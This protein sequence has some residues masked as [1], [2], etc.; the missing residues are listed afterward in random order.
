MASSQ[1]TLIS[2]ELN[3]IFNSKEHTY[4][5]SAFSKTTKKKKKHCF[6]SEKFSNICFQINLVTIWNLLIFILKV[7]FWF[8]IWFFAFKKVEDGLVWKANFNQNVGHYQKKKSIFFHF[9][10]FIFY[11]LKKI[12]YTY[13]DTICNRNVLKNLFFKYNG[14]NKL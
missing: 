11:N 9:L 13:F 3:L 7:N 8:N 4:K 14:V 10:L 12:F 6:K 5:L 2:L 1:C